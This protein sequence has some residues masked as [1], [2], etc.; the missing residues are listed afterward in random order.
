M[1]MNKLSE[2]KRIRRKDLEKLDAYQT[3]R[4]SEK[5]LMQYS[6]TNICRW[7]ATVNKRWIPFG[8]YLVIV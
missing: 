4:V 5:R 7:E 2:Q 6:G 3:N 1:F 8:D